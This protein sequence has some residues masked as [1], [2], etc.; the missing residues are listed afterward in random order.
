MARTEG[1]AKLCV[2][3]SLILDEEEAEAL[4]ALT[5]YG[6]D[7]FIKVFYAHLGTSCLQPHEAGLRRLFNSIRN[8][9][10][11]LRT[12]LNKVKEAREVLRNGV[13]Q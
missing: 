11:G 5:M 2:E 3:V 9:T 6:E 12:E 4:H 7:A 13:C 8:N 10:A 1:R